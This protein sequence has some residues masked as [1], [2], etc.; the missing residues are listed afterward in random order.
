MR[1]VLADSNIQS[2]TPNSL[3][4]WGDYYY[5]LVHLGYEKQ[6]PL[7]LLPTIC[8]FAVSGT[9]KNYDENTQVEVN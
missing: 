7:I 5:D 8:G 9:H 1:C 4:I 3:L 2:N 6:G